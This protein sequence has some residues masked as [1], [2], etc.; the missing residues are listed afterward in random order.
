MNCR[1]CGAPNSEHDHRCA[2][3]GRR[4]YLTPGPEPVGVA[5][6]AATAPALQT[7]TAPEPR[8]VAPPHQPA[9]FGGREPLRVVTMPPSQ[10][11]RRD[12]ILRASPAGPRSKDESQQRL[13]FPN[14]VQTTVQPSEE[15][16]FG[17]APV[18]RP[19]HRLLA[20]AIDA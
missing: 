2:K 1:Y 14:P 3:C 11:S 19:E 15:T 8:P 6:R 4:L 17:N 5:S 13:S 20:A 16:I 7:A 10:T 12:A 18:A 9:L